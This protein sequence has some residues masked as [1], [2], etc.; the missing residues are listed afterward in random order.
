MG[1]LLRQ[2]DRALRF[3]VIEAEKAHYDINLLCRMFGVSR[4][5]YYAWERRGESKHEAEDRRLK[6]LVVEAHRESGGRYGSPKIYESLKKLDE[7]VSEKRV[8]R[9][10]REEGL[11]G[12]VKRKS[13]RWVKQTPGAK[14]DNVIKRDFSAAE[15]DKVWVVDTTFLKVNRSFIYLAVVLDLY[16]RRIVGW[17][18]SSRNDTKLILTA[19][20]D[21]IAT[22]KAKPG[23]IHHSDRGS[24]YTSHEYMKELKT[25]GFISSM[26]APGACLDNAAMESWFR[27]LKAELGER[28]ASLDQARTELFDFIE[29]FYNRKRIH[30]RLGYATPD[31]IER[32]W[33]KKAA[34]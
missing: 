5:G 30:S 17:A 34:A 21:A 29:R 6:A 14:S 20:R 22:R 10:M 23:L 7:R 15:P 26:S 1:G 18:V 28:F 25:R 3:S 11:C 4:S 32:R 33:E 13:R 31:E 9:L 27:V 24:T 2:G 8:A 19:L 12:A 16:A